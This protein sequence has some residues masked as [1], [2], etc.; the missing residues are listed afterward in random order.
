[1][2]LADN[3]DR[4]KI[5]DEFEFPPD[6]TIDFGVT[7]PFVPKTLIFTLVR[8]IACFNCN[9]M[10]LAD[11]PDRHKI[12]DEFEFQPDSTIDWTVTCP[13]VPEN[14]VFHLVQSIACL[15]LIGSI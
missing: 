9:F 6:R 11:N 1:M 15:V 3:M 13:L 12:L 4:H 5:S 10:K 7:C 14:P 8:S 2:K